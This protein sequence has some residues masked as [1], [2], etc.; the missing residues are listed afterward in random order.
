MRRRSQNGSVALVALCC[1]AVLGIALASYLAVSNQSMK[2]SNRTY[3]KDVSRHLAEM[4]LERALRAFS[5]NTFSGSWTVSGITATRTLSINSSNYGTSGITT[6]IYLRVDHYLTGNKA[7]PWSGLTSYAANDYVSYLGVWYNC[8]LAP[9]SNQAPSNITYW[10]AAPQP[11]KADST[12]QIGNIALSGGSA[13][14]CIAANTNQAPPS[15]TYWTA[16]TAAAWSSG[17]TYAVDDV[18]TFGGMAYRCILGHIN[19]SPPNTTYWLSAPV[20]YSQGV[21]TLSDGSAPI[22]TQLRALIAPAPLFPNAAAAT[23]VLLINPSSGTCMIDSYNS[24]LGTYASQVGNAATNYSAVLA[25][26]S[27]STTPSATVSRSTVK[28]YVAA[29]SASTAPYAPRTSFGG[30]TTV[31]SATSPVSPNVDLTRVSRS[32]YIPQFDVQSVTGA[33]TLVLNVGSNTDIGTAGATTPSKYVINGDL[34][35]NQTGSTLTIHGP[36]ILDVQGQIYIYNGSG[37]G[38]CRIIIKPTGSAE[39]HFSG[40]LYIGSYLGSL[41]GIDNQTLD[42][43]KLI[44]IGTNTTNTTG[45]HYFWSTLPF[46]GVIYMPNAYL[47]LWGNVNIYGAVSASNIGYPNTSTNIHYDTTLRTAAFGGVD[48][49]YMIWEL[50]ELTNPSETVTLP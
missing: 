20:I 7:V 49:P 16:Y 21:A 47:C 37:S 13:Y 12:Y 27:T 19:Q 42:P 28:G 15:A 17:T 50:R 11:W 23:S 6:A 25:G 18:V 39:I 9:P 14:R 10:Q 31:K 35:L 36:V 30:T 24:A 48:A 29:A 5:F 46:Y 32:P 43:K 8:I 44:I 22:T 34:L 45:Y 40:R 3:A 33:T 38:G 2:L 26:G 1:V 4:G 41:D